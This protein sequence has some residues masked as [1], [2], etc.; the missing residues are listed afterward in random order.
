MELRPYQQKAVDSIFKSWGEFDKTLL[1]LPTGC[2]KTV[3]FAKVAERALKDGGK[4]LVLAHREELLT[5]ARDKIAAVTG[6]SCAFEK[7]GESAIDSLYPITCASVQT[8]MRE[9]RLR[10]FSPDH[11]GTIIVD[12][13]HHALSDSYQNILRY[14]S[15]AKVLGVT[16]TP[17]RGDKQNLG[18]YFEDIAYEYSIRD[19]IKEGYLSKI[20]VQTI[21]LK[22]SLKGVK[23]TAG[24]YSADDLGSA[25]DP[26]LEEI[27]KH[28]PRERKTLIFLPLI[29]T[30][31]RMAQS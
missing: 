17:D 27:A 28:I 3:C 18:K 29:A 31:Q 11:Y 16:A 10:R 15:S 30:S 7:A 6:L 21:P 25:I 1:V 14:F 12:E 22:I 5:Q 2:G 19:A 9:S 26:Y 13:A 23:T 4:A 24:D 20:L 8:L